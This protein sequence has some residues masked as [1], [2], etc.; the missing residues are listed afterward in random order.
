MKTTCIRT[1]RFQRV[2]GNYEIMEGVHLIPHTTNGLQ[3]IGKRENMY[4][5]ENGRWR[6][7]DFSHEQSLVFETDEGLVIFNSCCHGGAD[8]IIHE[9][10]NTFPGKKIVAL[11]GGFHLFNKS[12]TFVRTLAQRIKA[13][14]IQQV[15]TGHC[16][17]QK[18]FDILKEELGDSVHQ[19][20]IGL[21][22]DF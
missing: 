18:A 20:K 15:Y 5:K 19:L 13:T 11:I 8:T 9:V 3:E 14:G 17:G 6:P 10:E 1:K 2:S 7:D 21:E 22:M 4:R 16:T 12:E